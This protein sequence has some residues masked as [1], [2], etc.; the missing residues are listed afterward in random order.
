MD[1]LNLEQAKAF[2]TKDGSEIREL[3][4]TRSPF[5]RGGGTSPGML[6]VTRCICSVAAR[7]RMSTT[8]P[9]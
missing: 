1:I 6:V 2:I 3:L 9:C 5:H 4:G 8:I 7:P